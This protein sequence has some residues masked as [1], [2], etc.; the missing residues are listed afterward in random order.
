MLQMC[1]LYI[2]YILRTRVYKN[3]EISQKHKIT[4]NRIIKLQKQHC[5]AVKR[6]PKYDTAA[7]ITVLK[8]EIN[9]NSPQGRQN[10]PLRD[11]KCRKAELKLTKSSFF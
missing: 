7:Y 6:T 11:I 10:P 8:Y 3:G 5:P 2:K 4:I 9:I 1:C